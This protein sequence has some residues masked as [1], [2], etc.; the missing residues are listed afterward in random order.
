MFETAF[1][2]QLQGSQA[3][4]YFGMQQCLPLLDKSDQNRG[5]TIKTT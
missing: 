5:L 4:E 3:N 1:F 2:S